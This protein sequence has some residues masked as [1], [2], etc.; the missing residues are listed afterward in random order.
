VLS[1]QEL[2]QYLMEKIMYWKPVALKKEIAL[3]ME[4]PQ[5][6]LSEWFDVEKMD[7]VL[8]NLIFNAI[9]YTASHG[10]VTVTLTSTAQ[11][12]QIT[13]SDDG[14]G[15]PKP[16]I[17]KM[18]RRFYRAENAINLQESGSGLGLLLVK[19]YVTLHGGQ[20]GVNSVEGNG[21]DFFIR[22]KRGTSHFTNVVMLDN[23]GL[24]MLSGKDQPENDDGDKMKIKL[25]I[26]EDNKDLREYLKMSL[27][28]YYNTCSAANGKEAWDNMHTVNPDIIVSDLNMPLMD[29]LELCR[30]VKTTYDTS[31]IPVILLTV[32]IEKQNVEAGLRTGADDY[33]LKPFDVKYLRIKIDNIINNRKI[34]RAKFL[35][36]DKQPFSGETGDFL[37][38]AFIGKATQI[39]H[40][41]LTDTDFSVSDLSKEMG[42][43][44]SLLYTKF[45]AVT[46]Y[47]PNDF[48]KIVRMKRAILLFR[49]KKYS[50]NEVAYMTGFGEPSYFTACFKK[51][52]GKTPKQFIEEEIGRR[53]NGRSFDADAK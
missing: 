48:I 14:I 40:N 32:M 23:A 33:I 3:N 50:I 35:N 41:H 46:G 45:N 22:L 2:E 39:I 17:A 1:R 28:H 42:M 30:K 53:A 4:C 8:D 38:E 6:S 11:Y 37:N 20:V 26:V 44:R 15:I 51:I 13:V 5:G 25:L 9:K 19:N 12:W 18:F 27:G 16:D 36:M 24:P 21:S 52:Y 31:H 34:L 10:H 49:E 47:S 29:G 43:S 7:K